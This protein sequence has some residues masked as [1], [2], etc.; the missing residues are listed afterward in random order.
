MAG[1]FGI[2]VGI[3]GFVT[4]MMEKRA[5]RERERVLRSLAEDF[6]EHDQERVA[7]PAA[8][9][10]DLSVVQWEGR[11]FHANDRIRIAKWAGTIKPE[12][13][14]A[15]VELHANEGRTGVV[16]SGEKRQKPDYDH[17]SPDPNERIQIVR[18]RWEPQKWKEFGADRWL[19]LPAFEST[20]HVSYLE[21][22]R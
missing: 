14:G 6:R 2:L 12:E 15:K 10:S 16:I 8:A 11:T 7:A 21:V 3:A 9:A 22:V 13:S 5:A 20:I 19:E 1:I 17:L 4:V 18:V